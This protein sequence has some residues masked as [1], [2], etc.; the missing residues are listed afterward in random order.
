LSTMGAI[1]PARLDKAGVRHGSEDGLRKWYLAAALPQRARSRL[2]A[3]PQCLQPGPPAPGCATMSV[4]VLTLMVLLSLPKQKTDGRPGKGAIVRRIP[5]A[6]LLKHCSASV[7][8]RETPTM[9]T[10]RRVDPGGWSC[11]GST[12]DMPAAGR[13]ASSLAPAAMPRAAR[14][15]AA[16]ARLRRNSVRRNCCRGVARR[17]TKLLPPA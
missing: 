10:R 4:S 9:L 14:I 17:E 5:D 16:A 11:L 8:C 15:P 13:A 2:L 7:P 3:P 1:L 6:A 12:R